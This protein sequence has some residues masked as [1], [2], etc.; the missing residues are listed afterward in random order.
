MNRVLCSTG[1]LI[2]RPNGR[3]WRLLAEIAPRLECDGFEFMLYSS[4]YDELDELTREIPRMGLTFPT[5]HCEKGLGEYLTRGEL[6]EAFRR[7]DVNCEVASALGARLMVLH[8]WNGVIS[9]SAIENNYSALSEL[10]ARAGKCGLTLT[11]ENVVCNVSDPQTHL[12]EIASRF[13]EARF[14]FDTKM[15]AFH[16]QLDAIFA[17]GREHFHRDGRI[18]H[19]HI[20]DYGGGYKDWTKLRTLSPG[21]GNIDF[22]GFFARLGDYG[23]GGDFTVEATAFDESGRL[24]L[25][26]LN[27]AFA[28]VRELSAGLR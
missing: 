6:D 20:N 28:A 18:A 4:W 9:D 21:E 15:A 27:R 26:R 16:G 25:E 1:A 14:T 11:V 7:F 2:G 22:A 3:N 23:Y 12:D 10:Y 13:P 5:F 8:L 19:L 17:P 24:G